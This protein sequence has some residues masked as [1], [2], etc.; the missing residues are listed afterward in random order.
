MN[1]NNLLKTLVS[2]LLLSSCV[3]PAFSN[4]EIPGDHV[5]VVWEAAR[6]RVDTELANRG[7]GVSRESARAMIN[8][9]GRRGLQEYAKDVKAERAGLLIEH[10]R[11]KNPPP[12][13]H[14]R[15][16]LAEIR[17]D[18]NG[19]SPF[20]PI[21]ESQRIGKTNNW[22]LQFADEEHIIVPRPVG[23]HSGVRVLA[24]DYGDV[25]QLTPAECRKE[26]GFVPSCHPTRVLM[27]IPRKYAEDAVELPEL[28]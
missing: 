18:T 5:E 7:K 25:K 4:D 28:K 24:G 14:Q 8:W 19:I 23:D 21:Y 6:L 15:M 9:R 2:I 12:I 22:C 17:G 26:F 3:T 16:P 10:R 27:L 20:G 13:L 11:L 1:P